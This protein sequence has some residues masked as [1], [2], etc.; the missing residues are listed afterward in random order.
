MYTRCSDDLTDKHR[1]HLYRYPSEPSTEQVAT[2]LVDV[3]V[4]LP[5]YGLHR[6]AVILYHVNPPLGIQRCLYPRCTL[7]E[8]L[9]GGSPFD[10]DP[11]LMVVMEVSTPDLIPPETV[12]VI[13]Q[14]GILLINGGTGLSDRLNRD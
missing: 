2:S 9:Y 8:L 5:H 12:V 6:K 3:L 1:D 10:D 11:T 4:E 13:Y 14:L 7:I